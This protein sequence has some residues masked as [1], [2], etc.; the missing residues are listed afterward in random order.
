MA[1]KQKERPTVKCNKCN[2]TGNI[3][4]FSHI[5]GGLCFD[6][7]GAGIL[8]APKK[9]TVKYSVS[10]CLPFAGP[11]FF[12]A[13][14]QHMEKILCIGFNGHPTAEQWIL[15]D[16]EFYYIGQPVCRSSTWWK[17]PKDTFIEF[18]E[19]YDKAWRQR[20]PILPLFTQ[21]IN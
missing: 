19:N 4:G 6:C 10:Y 18:L 11:G 20:N 16:E 21:I 17:V 14:Y 8:A 13:E 15:K 3:Q 7:N 1:T 5:S 2:G 9:S 12:P